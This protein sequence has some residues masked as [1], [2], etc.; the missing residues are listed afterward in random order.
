M[1]KIFRDIYYLLHS[2]KNSKLLYFLK[3]E[4]LMRVPR[5]LLRWWL[6]GSP[7]ANASSLPVDEEMRDRV[8]YYCR[9]TPA[10][11]WD[12]AEWRRRSVRLGDQRVI[13]PKVYYYDSMI[14]AR[15]FSPALRWVLV[16][17]DIAVHLPVPSVTKSR[18][19]GSGN[20]CSVL[21]KLDKV[22]HYIYVND[23]LSWKEKLD[24]AVFRGGIGG[25]RRIDMRKSFVERWFGHPL[26]DIGVLDAE[27]PEWRTRPMTIREQLAYKFVIS[28]EGFD[29]ASNLK[30]VMSSNSIAVMPR[31]VTETWFMEGRLVPNYHYIEVKPDFSDVEER[32]RH[33]LAHPEEAE[34]IVRHQHEWVARFRDARRESLISLMVLNRYFGL[35]N[36]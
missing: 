15:L 5:P 8:D 12:E 19:I 30:W 34:A 1:R 14:Y 22:R 4:W 25:E 27:F 24:R 35:T 6:L 32:L 33:Y 26:F 29:V 23:R 16:P 13:R 28:L 10:S 36:H 7:R 21:M 2:G 3:S 17:G 11:L 18:P 31:P 20:E 9:L